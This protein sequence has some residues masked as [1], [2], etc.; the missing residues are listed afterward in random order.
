M[1]LM[2]NNYPI[3]KVLNDIASEEGTIPIF[4]YNDKSMKFNIRSKKYY[5]NSDLCPGQN[6]YNSM[7]KDI[8]LK[9]Q[10][11]LKLALHS[12]YT[13]HDLHEETIAY[14]F[15]YKFKELKDE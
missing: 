1:K 10:E 13:P 15:S 12:Y 4:A 14:K 3:K 8:Y 11:W 6:H 5:F 2:F 7:P 9:L